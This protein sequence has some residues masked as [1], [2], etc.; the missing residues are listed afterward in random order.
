[1]SRQYAFP[2][3]I[4]S[5][6]R[7]AGVQIA[8][9]APVLNLCVALWLVALLNTPFWRALWQAAG[10]WEASRAGFLLSLPIFVLLWVWLL[11]ECLTW[12]RAAKPVLAAVVLVSTAAAYFMST[13]GVVFDR[14][15]I[16]SIIDTDAAETLELLSLRM[17]AWMAVFAAPPLWLL[18]RVRL[19]RQRWH[20]HLLS[21]AMILG[22]AVSGVVV[23]VAPFFQYYAPLL[24]NHRELRLHLVPS[25][26]FAAV[27]SHIKARAIRSEAFERVALD[28]TRIPAAP[29]ASRPALL[30]LVI[31]ETARAAN[32]ALN[33]YARETTPRMVVEAGVI[34]FPHVQSCGTSTTV[35]LPCMFLDVGRAGFSESLAGRRENLLDV[36]QR[37]GLAVLWRDNNSGC[38]GLCDRI[39]LD[40]FTHVNV[41]GLC[42]SGECHDEVLL[43]GLQEKLDAIDRDA[44]VVLH[45]KGSH[46][47]SYYLR[48]P[49]AFEHFTPVCTTNQLDRCEPATIVNAY[50][51]SLRY[52]DYVLARTIELLR[53][54]A[55]RFDTS[56][57]YVSDH[58]ESLG[59]HGL[60]LHGVPYSIAPAEQ[61]HVPMLMWFSPGATERFGI[62]AGCLRTR[63]DELLSHD[64]LYHST[65]GLLG[66]Q[67]RV[68]R[69]ELDLFR[70][71]RTP[72]DLDARTPVEKHAAVPRAQR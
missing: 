15:M 33:G 39:Q 61:T 53:R 72:R 3:I 25:N 50:D 49:P 31:G 28:A 67:T 40:D 21:K 18:S 14:S 12:G 42:T 35:S 11:L 10:G 41:P 54:N 48:Y 60:Y 37:A 26:Y 32:F 7:F 4:Q 58:G 47:P 8:L 22:A 44:V 46:G 5:M 19:A 13:Y 56:L 17:L 29:V 68:Y 70:T 24:R 2:Q 52:T 69:P 9:T 55:K 62:D 51:N 1:M 16:A 6:R 30:V 64:N 20:R 36:L 57:V 34:N 71:C 38:K 23:V 27:H 43:H 45:M 63:S 66:V 59:E 65:L